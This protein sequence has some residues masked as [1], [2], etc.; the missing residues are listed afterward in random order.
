VYDIVLPPDQI[1]ALTHGFDDDADGLPD[2]V[3]RRIINANPN[4]APHTL[5]E[6][7]PT[8]DYDGD[9][10]S[11]QAEAIAGTDPTSATDFFKIVNLDT[12]GSETPFSIFVDGKKGRTYFLERSLDLDSEWSP[13][14]QFGPLSVDR[15]VELYDDAPLGTAAFYKVRVENM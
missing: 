15:T 11:N 12:S 1:I 9:H 4:A 6:V 14:F 13:I 2:E 8:D 7:L 10:S 5:A 3:E